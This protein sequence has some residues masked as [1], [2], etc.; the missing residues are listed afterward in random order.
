MKYILC[1]IDSLERLN[2]FNRINKQLTKKINTE[3]IFITTALSIYLKGKLSKQK[4]H[5]VR[6]NK[7]LLILKNEDRIKNTIQFQANFISEQ[8]CKNLYNSIFLTM[9]K[10]ISNHRKKDFLGIFNWNGSSINSK[11]S[12]SISQKYKIPILFFEIG[13]FKDQIFIDKLGTNSDSSIAKNPKLLL[14]LKGSNEEFIKWKKNF[15]KNRQNLKTIPQAK[16]KNPIKTLR[17]FVN[18][19]IDELGVFILRTPR[20][21]PCIFKRILSHLK[22]SLT[23]R[24]IQRLC[25]SKIPE[26]FV[27]LPLQVSTDTNL[28]LR[29]KVDNFKAI[30]IAYK[31][32]KSKHL[33]LIIKTHPADKNPVFLKELYNYIKEKQNTGWNIIVS[34]INAFVLA[35]KAEKIF[36]IN[37]TLGLEAI[38]YG[39]ENI[40]ILGDA[41]YKNWNEEHIKNYVT[42]FLIHAPY[43]NNE[44][45]SEESVEKI[46][47]RLHN[48]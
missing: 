21:K 15:I 1:Y 44:D 6:K 22:S 18:N 37:S 39:V 40:E 26:K 7:K 31:Y 20:V 48:E 23:K 9:E 17:L 27:F 42:E 2:F 46:I 38:I 36:T 10:I 5:L 24:K 28:L 34:N 47:K 33:P 45:I 14:N 13:N 8:Q 12:E 4:I 3:I 43:F 35:K 41:L 16:R 19:I 11:A 29:S 25:T 32:A 30:E